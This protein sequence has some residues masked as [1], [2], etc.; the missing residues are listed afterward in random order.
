MFLF[1]YLDTFH[2]LQISM[3]FVSFWFCWLF[4]AV[5]AGLIQIIISIYVCHR[6]YEFL[7]IFLPF[8]SKSSKTPF[9]HIEVFDEQSLLNRSSFGIV[10]N[11]IGV[12]H[13]MYQLQFLPQKL[14]L[15]KNWSLRGEVMQVGLSVK[16]QRYLLMQPTLSLLLDNYFVLKKPF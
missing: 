10:S 5:S 3:C 8:L 15:K 4:Q 13:C 2:S 16:L 6:T 7:R 14:V 12:L 1:I 11:V 9:I